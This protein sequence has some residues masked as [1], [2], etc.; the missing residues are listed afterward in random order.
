MWSG[1]GMAWKTDYFFNLIVSWWA[2]AQIASQLI[3]VRLLHTWGHVIGWQ[4]WTQDRVSTLRPLELMQ[5]VMELLLGLNIG[6]AR[7]VLQVPRW[8]RFRFHYRWCGRWRGRRI[9]DTELRDSENVN[10]YLYYVGR[11]IRYPKE[12]MK[13][14]PH[15]HSYS[16]FLLESYFSK[17]KLHFLK[18]YCDLDA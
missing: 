3:R 10:K 5:L 18:T 13:M 8:Q 11:Y 2:C 9:G 12:I 7:M 16:Q 6:Q 15:P 14:D 4:M 1:S 17:K